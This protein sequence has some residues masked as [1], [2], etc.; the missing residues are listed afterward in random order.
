[1]PNPV[2]DKLRIESSENVSKV[3]IYDLTGKIQFSQKIDDK[4]ITL[5]TDLIGLNENGMYLCKL[6]INNKS[7]VKKI[8]VLK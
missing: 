5:D 8:V 6:W 1:L 7:I 4:S 3:E 2:Q